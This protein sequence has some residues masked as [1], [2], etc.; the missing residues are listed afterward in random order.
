[1]NAG[2]QVYGKE[3]N[4]VLNEIMGVTERPPEGNR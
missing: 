4:A 1:M 3:V 2:S